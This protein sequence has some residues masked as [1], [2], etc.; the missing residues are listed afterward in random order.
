[1]PLSYRMRER[2]MTGTIEAN[3]RHI[4]ALL[5]RIDQLEIVLYQ[6]ER[7]SLLLKERLE[8]NGIDVGTTVVP[9]EA[10]H[11]LPRHWHDHRTAEAVRRLWY[12]SRPV[13]PE[14][15]GFGFCRV[16]TRCGTIFHA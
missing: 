12:Q 2:L 8:A 13:A 3:K 9:N 10:S 16:T 15:H 11:L 4:A 14:G 1:M 6:Q 5:C 7:I